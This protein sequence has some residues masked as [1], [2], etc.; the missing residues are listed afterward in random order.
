MKLRTS[1]KSLEV[2]FLKLENDL[3]LQTQD[4]LSTSHT[5][6]RP[7]S[8]PALNHESQLATLELGGHVTIKEMEVTSTFI[9]KLLGLS[10]RGTTDWLRSLLVILLVLSKNSFKGLVS[11]GNQR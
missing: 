11:G 6:T 7:S 4:S 2:K 1:K 3:K 10:C 8:Q 9:D 5:S